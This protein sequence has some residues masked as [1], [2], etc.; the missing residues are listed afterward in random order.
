MRPVKF[1]AYHQ[2]LKQ[3]YYGSDVFLLK[4][5]FGRVSADPDAYELNQW[6]GLLDKVGKEIYEGGIV[7]LKT[8]YEKYEAE[9]KWDNGA[10]IVHNKHPFRMTGF[11]SQLDYWLRDVVMV[12]G[13]VKVEVIGN[14][15]ESKHLLDK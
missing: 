4:E 5:L 7:S 2:M 6:T 13:L 9:V 11:T 12:D 10:Y 15:Y 8:D 3:F 1:R 14:I